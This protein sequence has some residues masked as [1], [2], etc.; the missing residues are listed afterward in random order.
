ME[1]YIVLLYNLLYSRSS[2]IDRDNRADR[3][4]GV[5]CDDCNGRPEEES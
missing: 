1:E 5:P 2:G 3:Y 4:S